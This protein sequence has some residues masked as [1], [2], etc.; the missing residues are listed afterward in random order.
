[1]GLHFAELVFENHNLFLS[2]FSSVSQVSFCDLSE[3][4][5]KSILL[6]HEYC[7]HLVPSSPQP[8]EMLPLAEGEKTGRFSPTGGNMYTTWI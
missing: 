8:T 1:M 4:I 7:L 2:S 5:K 3:E 6:L